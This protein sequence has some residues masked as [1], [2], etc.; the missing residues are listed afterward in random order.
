MRVTFRGDW[1]HFSVGGI[2]AL[3][4]SVFNDRAWRAAVGGSLSKFVLPVGNPKTYFVA[5]G[6]VTTPVSFR[7]IPSDLLNK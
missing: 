5:G 4:I 3:I 6:G 7:I 1:S 2:P